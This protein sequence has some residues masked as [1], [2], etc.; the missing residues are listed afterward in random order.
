MRMSWDTVSNAV[1]TAACV[2]IIVLGGLQLRNESVTPLGP[3]PKTPVVEKV[4][5]ITLSTGDAQWQGAADAKGVVVEFSD[6]QCPYCGRFARETYA[7]IKREFVDTGQL[8]YTFLHFPL[9][10]HPLAE[11]AGEAAECA[12]SQGKFWGMHDR[13]FQNQELLNEPN[14]VLHAEAL[15]LRRDS[16]RSCLDGLMTSRVKR[17]FQEGQ[18]V[19]VKVTP[20]FLLGH[21]NP[22]NTVTIRTRIVGAQPINAC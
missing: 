1:F 13:L 3:P 17:H 7:E 21:V 8:R 6:F 14:L 16:F 10:F 9:D 19:G 2:M 11:K 12:G 20:T 18:R 4:D 22:D 5:E 15:G